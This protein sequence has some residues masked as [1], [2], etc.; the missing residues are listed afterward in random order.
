MGLAKKIALGTGRQ[1][2]HAQ[3]QV[4]DAGRGHAR[5]RDDAPAR[6]WSCWWSAPYTV[7]R[8]GFDVFIHTSVLQVRPITRSLSPS[9]SMSSAATL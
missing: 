4:V 7:E 6:R 2:G 8:Q 9:R 5:R 1:A 3:L